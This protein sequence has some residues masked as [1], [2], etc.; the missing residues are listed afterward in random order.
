MTAESQEDTNQRL[1]LMMRLMSP[2]ES[3]AAEVAAAIAG[4]RVPAAAYS[5]ARR[6]MEHG[7]DLGDIQE[8]TRLLQEGAGDPPALEV[9]AWAA[10]AAWLGGD[11]EEEQRCLRSLLARTAPDADDADGTR[12]WI[13]VLRQIGEHGRPGEAIDLLEPYL[14]DHPDD[15][16]ASFCHFSLLRK[17]AAM[18]EPGEQDRGAVA[19]F[20]DHGGLATF[21]KSVGAYL[22]AHPDLDKFVRANAAA[23]FG[24]LTGKLLPEPVLSEC[25][26]LVFEAALR[27]ADLAAAGLTAKQAF[28]RVKT[29]GSL[30]ET[31]LRLMAADPQ[32]P[33][34]DAR[35]AF[36]WAEHGQYGLWQVHDPVPDPGVSGRDLATGAIRYLS[37]PPGALDGAAPWSVWL[38]AAVPLDGAWRV[39][40]T[41][42]MLSPDEADAVAEALSQEVARVIQSTDEEIPL[43]EM[44][45]PAPV[46]YGSAPPHGCRWDF[47]SPPGGNWSG[48]VGGILMMIAAVFLAD[49]ELHRLHHPLPAPDPVADP[50][51]W[52]QAP[53]PRLHGLTPR[54]CAD[55]ADVN[56]QILIDSLF[57]AY[58]YQAALVLP[59]EPALDVPALRKELWPDEEDDE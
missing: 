12:E 28:R 41:G 43:A 57:H 52:A 11:A 55:T 33:P 59:G 17:A 26:A 42:I 1:D 35:R 36:Q 51:A 27:G 16:D 48:I 49:V 29:K 23:G 25:A 5:Y 15:E 32:T 7:A 18:A 21:R 9:L 20:T 50:A 2:E 10:E 8:T 47:T 54:Q 39:T 38:G 53:L 22:S 19:R 3:T 13:A 40:G 56:R 30:P 37:F 44:A 46:P 31:A 6:R 58:E 4:K 34:D 24:A 45:A 14:H